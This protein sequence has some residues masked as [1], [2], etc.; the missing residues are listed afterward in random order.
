[1]CGI[2]GVIKY[3]PTANETIS[4]VL[5]KMNQL[6]VHRGPDDDG[7]FIDN[8]KE[9][10]VGMAMRRL[11][12]I[13]LNTGKQPIYNEDKSIVIVFNGDRTS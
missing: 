12:I 4:E 11:S 10:S 9:F 8:T 3:Q 1:M 13:D 6:I 2:N 5:T 7:F